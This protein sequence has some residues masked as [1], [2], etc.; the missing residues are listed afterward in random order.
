MC[1]TVNEH[2]IRSVSRLLP[3]NSHTNALHLRD[4]FYLYS[5]LSNQISIFQY[6]IMVAYI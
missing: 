3:Q 6:H 1:D 2:I 4:V 5:K